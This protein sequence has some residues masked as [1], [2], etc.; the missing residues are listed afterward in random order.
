M[1]I[2]IKGNVFTISFFPAIVSSSTRM[3]AEAATALEEG[4]GASGAGKE[5]GFRWEE[6]P[7]KKVE[8]VAQSS[9][10]KTGQSV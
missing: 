6:V 2:I 10:P 4:A 5:W 9:A 7:E 1:I 3:S 8:K